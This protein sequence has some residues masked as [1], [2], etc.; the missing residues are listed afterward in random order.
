[1][2][3]AVVAVVLL[4]VCSAQLQ[5]QETLHAEARRRTDELVKDGFNFTHGVSVGAA[6]ATVEL[7][8]PPSHDDDDELYLWFAAPKGLIS[9]R[10]V[11]PDGEV[12]TSWKAARGEQRLVRHLA[13]GRYVAEIAGD[14]GE[15]VIGVKGP[16]IGRCSIDA[17]QLS[18][19]AAEPRNGFHWPYLLMTPKTKRAAVLLVLPN[20]SGFA[21]DDVELLRA[22][23]L[24]QARSEL[25]MADRLG[26]ALLV[27]LFPRPEIAGRSVNLYL[28]ALSRAALET[29]VPKLARVDLQL[30]AMI[31]HARALLGD[32]VGR[33]VMIEGFSAAGMFSNRFA[34]LHP[35]RTLA[36]AVG[37]PG[38][39]PIASVAAPG[40]TYPIG[41]ADV[42]QLTG[43][44]IDDAALRAVTF[45]FFLG[46]DDR[47]DSVPFR[48][49][50][51]AA[52]EALIMRRFGK[53]PVERWQRAEELYRDAGLRATFKLYPGVGHA[54]TPEMHS[55]VEAMF[56]AALARLQH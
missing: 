25:D 27:P 15:G 55:D 16:V 12:V 49:S 1:M 38:G 52:D 10:V 48:D 53:T 14:P 9:I 31:D 26:A 19:H 4:E 44:K 36:A 51:S 20:N 29:K 6:G 37:S 5:A 23:A 17:A 21:S 45:F 28:H 18:E 32:G 50:F 33:R 2:R 47:N 11:G 39:W 41:L 35:E 7:L 42:P 30:I 56:K 34:V 46:A 43:A 3:L 24:C 22:S 8:V 40:L 54:L 13:P